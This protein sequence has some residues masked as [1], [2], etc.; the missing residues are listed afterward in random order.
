MAVEK[1]D[2]ITEQSSK[3]EISAYA[4]QIAKEVEEE[5][6]GEQKSDAQIAS[7]HAGKP[8]NE[9][10][11][12]E[13]DSGSAPEGE[14]TAEVEDQGEETGDS[15]G[16]AKEWLDD[17]LKAEVAAYGIDEKELA[18]FTSREEVE[19]ALRFADQSDLEAG[20]KERAERDEKGRFAKKAPEP[21]S[22]PKEGQKT[23]YEP[24]L[25]KDL[26]DEEIAENLTGELAKLRDHYES[27]FGALE[28]RFAEADAMAKQQQ[29]D[30]AVDTMGHSDLFGKTG[31]ESR[32]ELERR[33]ELFDECED[34]M[35][36]R[37]LHGREAGSYQS[38]VN[39]VA[40]M[41]FADDLGKKDLKARTRSLSKQ[42][43]GRM[44]GGSVKSPGPE[45][46]INEWADRYYEELKGV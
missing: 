15:E 44:G 27:R 36:G 18:D 30:A 38:L 23:E 39:R 6:A 34:Y 7:E 21:E 25:N 4:E 17:D 10:T 22:K 26:W 42:A 46:T 12:A 16:Q 1:L 33:Q 40:R 37:Q 9:K 35:A 29:F 13:I 31:K 20:R 11:P 5:R 45:E 43:N 41:V 2:A 3:E 28:E 32:K 8:A 24:S 19:R 14:D